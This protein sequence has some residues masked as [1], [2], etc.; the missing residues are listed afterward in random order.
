[1]QMP[2]S[3]KNNCDCDDDQAMANQSV[4][5][6]P[7]ESGLGLATPEVFA[8]STPNPMANVNTVRYKL[9]ADADV[10][11]SVYDASGRIIKVLK[12]GKQSA[13]VHSVN[14]QADKMTNGVYFINIL[15]NGELKQTLRV[16]KE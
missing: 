6:F 11:V 4:G 1:M 13:G 12:Q 8:T 7:E 2:W 10:Q 14:W 5:R 3:G 15:K 16:I 9:D